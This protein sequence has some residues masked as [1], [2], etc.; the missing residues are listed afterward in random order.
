MFSGGKL[1]LSRCFRLG[2]KSP[3]E[4]RGAGSRG[5]VRKGDNARIIIVQGGKMR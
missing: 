1:L 5:W 3:Q 2:V 4:N